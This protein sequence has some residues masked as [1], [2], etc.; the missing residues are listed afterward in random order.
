MLGAY[1]KRQVNKKNPV[2]FERGGIQGWYKME[3]RQ[4]RDEILCII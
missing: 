4:D 3:R 1:K 2:N